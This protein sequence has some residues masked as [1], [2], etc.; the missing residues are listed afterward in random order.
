MFSNL[1]I[2]F[3]NISGYVNINLETKK[4]L[5]EKILEKFSINKFS[6][7]IRISGVALSSFLKNENSFIRINNLLNILSKLNISKKS[8]E[9]DIIL[10]RDTS[11]KEPFFIKFPYFLSPLDIRIM[12]VLIGDGNVHKDMIRW[13]Q[14]DPTPLKHLIEKVLGGD[15]IL[16]INKTQIV[17][18]SFFKK[19]LCFSFDLE[20]NLLA[21]EKFI[22]KT[23][24]LSDKYCLALLIAIIEDE[25]NIDPKNYGGILIRMSSKE[26]MFAIKK[27]C[28]HLNYKSSQ[29]KCYKNSGFGDNTMYRLTILSDGIKKLGYDLLK[30]KRKYGKEIGFWKKEDQF[31]R[32]WEIC[33]NKK[34]EKDRK[35][36]EIH[37]ELKDLFIK[38]ENL[39]PLQLSEILQIDYS[40]IYDLIRN[41]HKRNEIERIGKGIYAKN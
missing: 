9:G 33:I 37:N 23:L 34:A 40:R 32:R 13:I 36:R 41:M 16:N 11:S 1:K 25:G 15:V 27:L 28:D 3:W 24:E 22:K 20:P 14:K 18:P 21:S 39:S 6:K 31:N 8:V 19:V 17:I 7:K 2:H 38:Y 5:L 10:Y 26:I 30:L 12:G 4:F 35:G 29:I